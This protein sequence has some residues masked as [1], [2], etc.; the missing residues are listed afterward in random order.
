M[1]DDPRH[2]QLLAHI[3]VEGLELWVSKLLHC[4]DDVLRRAREDLNNDFGV[5]RFG[6]EVVK[7][8]TEFAT[9]GG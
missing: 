5:V 1:V 7:L 4:G 9:S 2:A 8:K 3:R 6:G